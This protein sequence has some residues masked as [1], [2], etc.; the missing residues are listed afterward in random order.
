MI[1][2]GCQGYPGYRD[3]LVHPEDDKFS[4]VFH[5]VQGILGTSGSTGK[6]S[7]YS[8]CYLNRER[9]GKDENLNI[10]LDAN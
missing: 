4:L 3:T 9:K 7:F 1:G 2:A 6:M 5:L 10:K 8:V